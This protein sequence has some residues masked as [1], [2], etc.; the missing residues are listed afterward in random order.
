[1]NYH[2]LLAGAFAGLGGLYLLYL[3]ETA[4]G[5][6]ILSGMMGF[7]V[8]EWNGERKGLLEKEAE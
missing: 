1:M 6:A 8:G 2:R 7:F 5:V 4:A 3:G